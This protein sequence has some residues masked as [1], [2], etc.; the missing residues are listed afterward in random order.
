MK[1][2]S[3][4]WEALHLPRQIEWSHHPILSSRDPS[5][6]NQPKDHHRP[7]YTV[8]N[9]V[10]DANLEASILCTS[11]GRRADGIIHSDTERRINAASW[12][13]ALT[14][15]D[16]VESCERDGILKQPW[17]SAKW[18]R[19]FLKDIAFFAEQPCLQ[20]YEWG[21]VGDNKRLPLQSGP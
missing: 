20:N 8:N 1:S 14:S 17:T 3:S 19:T 5:T 7:R 16:W 6:G 18:R 11:F 15:K 12:S 10:S 9:G 4:R 2:M 21:R 13:A